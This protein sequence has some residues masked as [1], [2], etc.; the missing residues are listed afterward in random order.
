MEMRRSRHVRRVIAALLAAASVL[1]TPALASKKNNSVVFAF[2][3]TVQSAD[4][5]FSVQLITQIVADQVWDTL[6]F[7]DPKTGAFQGN[8]ATSWRWI[9]EKTLELDLRQG[10]K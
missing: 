5:Y 8:L 10:V 9:D 3:Q 7:R 2:D 4:P 6:I 1:A